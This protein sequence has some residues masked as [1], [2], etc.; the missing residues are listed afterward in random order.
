MNPALAPWNE[1][2]LGAAR[3]AT[4]AGFLIGYYKA[5][6]YITAPTPPRFCQSCSVKLS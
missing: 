5:L 3:V 1:L 4:F 6:D 2:A